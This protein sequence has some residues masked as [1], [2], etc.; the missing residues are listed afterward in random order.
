MHIMCR[1][2]GRGINNGCLSLH[3]E[4]DNFTIVSSQIVETTVVGVLSYITNISLTEKLC[5]HCT[6]R[7]ALTATQYFL[8]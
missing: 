6:V 7:Q 8:S 4:K 5:H 1:K 3:C 2:I